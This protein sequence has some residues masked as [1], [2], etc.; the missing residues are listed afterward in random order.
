MDM[1][2]RNLLR[3]AS[4]V[5]GAPFLGSR[6]LSA[7]SD[8][9]P[10]LGLVRRCRPGDPDW[11]SAARWEELDRQVGGRLLQ[12]QS[13]LDACRDVPGGAACRAVMQQ[14]RNPYYLGDEP[15]LTQTSGWADAWASAPSAYAVAAQT[16]DDVVAAVTFARDNNLRLVVK[17][18]GHSYQGTSSAPDSLLVWTRAMHG[19]TL[20]DAFMGQG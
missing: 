2:R 12:V 18:G 10:A 7:R 4:G 11:P 16:A 19:I 17:G 3:G 9:S 20:H 5:L 14:L 13:P 15:A 1:D 6:P 8:A